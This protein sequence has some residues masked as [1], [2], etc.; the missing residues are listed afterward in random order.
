MASLQLN[1]PEAWTN[2]GVLDKAM[3][4]FTYSK[5]FK[6]GGFNGNGD[7]ASGNLTS[8]EPERVENYEVGVKFSMFDRRLIGTISR[9]DLRY[10]NIQLNVQNLD[11][12]SGAPVASIFNAGAAKIQG[13][14]FELQALLFDSLRLSLNGDFTEPRYTRFDDLSVPSGSRVGEPLSYIPDYRIS[15]SIE[16]RFALGG[17]MALTPRIQV[18]RTGERYLFNSSNM[19]ARLVG[20]VAPVTLTDAS[21]KLD[22]NERISF[23]FYGK[24][25]FNKK[26]AND[27]KSFGF[28]VTKWYA[29]PVTCGVI[30]RTKF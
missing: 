27:A 5:G 28:A 11:P 9:Y 30:A 13:I 24:N 15:G 17:E 2:N 7:T 29:P 10:T 6:S 26:Y 12:I 23:D 20:R 18:T 14:E 4:Y 19:T 25:I 22:L 3:A 21:L 8:F 1:A 16:N